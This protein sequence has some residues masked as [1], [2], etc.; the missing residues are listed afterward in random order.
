MTQK[1]LLKSLA[2]LVA[3]TGVLGRPNGR[4]VARADPPAALEENA[5][6]D[7]IKFQPVLDYDTDSCYNVAAI[8]ADGNVAEGLEPDGGNLTGDCR[9]E[10]DLDNQNVYSRTRCN[11]DWCVAM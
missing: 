9:D 2:I 10:A 3:V 4:L 8:D 11:N 6:D 1:S 5:P 7:A